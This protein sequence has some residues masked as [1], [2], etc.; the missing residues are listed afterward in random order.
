MLDKSQV[1]DGNGSD[2]MQRIIRKSGN[3]QF[4]NCKFKAVSS[5][6]KDGI[7]EKKR[8]KTSLMIL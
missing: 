5:F 2:N 8:C 7:D 1:F 6:G 4:G 3:P